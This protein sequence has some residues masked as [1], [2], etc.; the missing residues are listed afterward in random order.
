MTNAIVGFAKCMRLKLG[1]TQESH[2][3]LYSH[4]FCAVMMQSKLK[5]AVII[6]INISFACC[7][8]IMRFKVAFDFSQRTA[9]SCQGMKWFNR[10][11]CDKKQRHEGTWE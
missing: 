3:W 6:A 9:S 11:L 7:R 8:N 2:L 1:F 5:V 4:A 10:A